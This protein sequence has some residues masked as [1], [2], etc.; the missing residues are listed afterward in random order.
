LRPCRKEAITSRALMIPSC[1]VMMDLDEF[2]GRVD[3]SA[4]A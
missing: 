4:K 3:E 1:R 2:D